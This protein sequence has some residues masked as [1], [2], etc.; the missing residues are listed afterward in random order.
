MPVARPTIAASASGELN[1]RSCA[2]LVLQPKRQLEN[3]ALAFHQLALQVF[4]AAAIGHVFAEDHDALVAL[5]LV[6]QG[7]VDQIGHGLRRG[8]LAVGGIWTDHRLRVERRRC[9]IEIGRIHI[10][11]HALGRGRQSFERLIHRSLKFFFNFLFQIVDALFVEDALAQQEHL[12]ARNWI[13][14][15]VALALG[16]RTVQAFIVGKRMRIGTNHVRM[17]KRR[18]VALAAILRG[19]LECAV[20]RHRIGAVDFFEMKIR[21]SRDQPRNAAS[22]RLHFHRHRDRVAVILHAENYRQLVE[23]SRVHRLPEFTFAGGAIAQRNISDFIAVEGHILELA[24]V[25]TSPHSLASETSA[26]FGCCVKYRPAS[27]HPTACRICDPVGD[28]WVTIF[29]RR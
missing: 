25:R 9:R 19:A 15:R 17:H 29:S 21:K 16:V 18:P 24:I 2:K 4:F 1:T 13:A 7:H 12:R 28:D 10:L 22:R 6:A 3:S 27:A 5:H 8:L 20:T 26:A 23:R 11:H 14:G